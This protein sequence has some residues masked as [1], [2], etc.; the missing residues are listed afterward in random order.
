M[1]SGPPAAASARRHGDASAD[2]GGAADPLK[3]ASELFSLGRF[4]DSLADFEAALAL[5]QPTPQL[6]NSFGLLL[7]SLEQHEAAIEKF[8]QVLAMQPDFMDARVHLGR[9]L[10]ALGRNAQALVHC[11]A[12]LA[13]AP[14]H[15]GAHCYASLALEGLNAPEAALR[16]AQRSVEIAPDSAEGQFAL[17]QILV[18]H[19]GLEPA[20]TA[21]RRA[22]QLAPSAPLYYRAFGEWF[23]LSQDAAAL[24]GLQTLALSAD[25]SPE[26]DRL[27]LYFAL[28]KVLEEQGRW[29]EAMDHL[30]AAN[31]I[32]RRRSPYDE[33]D[34]LG[35]MDRVRAAFDSDRLAALAGSGEP[36][37]KPIFIVGMPRSGTTL[38]EQVLAAHPDVA[39][40]GELT[41]LGEVVMEG[42]GGGP[43]TLDALRLQAMGRRYIEL[44]SAM[45]PGAR[46]FTDKMPGNFVLIGMIRL[47]LPGAHIIH[48]RRD[49]IDTCLSCFSKLFTRGQPFAN[50]LGELGRYY[51]GYRALMAHWR[52][53]L[54]PGAML[55]ID[56]EDLVSDFPAQAARL[57]AHC[58][59]EWSPACLAFDTAERPVRTASA[60]QVRRPIYTT[61]VGR[62]RRYGDLLK[63]LLDALG[64]L[65]GLELQAE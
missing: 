5:V 28:H 33:A 4:Q 50:D 12:V 63:P 25:T 19:G 31:A 42:A 46:R 30:I 40:G 49:P 23:G 56:Y 35:L 54:P 48:V 14:D 58:G 27:H 24:Q 21:L 6:L 55:E 7:C 20:R 36:C 34:A 13:T 57:L 37:P 26:G 16:H 10:L 65:D 15:A 8:A 61:A 22:I 29:A 41:T 3:R 44:V 17:G 38:V 52:R 60:A 18:I 47:M 53:T 2:G 62:G 51:R 43:A 1:S 45:G 32:Q 39:A 59:L 64:N 9:S 11:N